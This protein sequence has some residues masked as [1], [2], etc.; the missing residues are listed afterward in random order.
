[1]KNR[2]FI[3]MAIGILVVFGLLLL[4]FA[5]WTP[6]KVRYYTDRLQSDDAD[7]RINATRELLRIGDEGRSVVFKWYTLLYDSK[8]VVQRIKIVDELCDM[9]DAGRNIMREIFI[10][11]CRYEQVR[12]PAGSFM[13][14]S[15]EGEEC[16]KPVHEVT[17]SGFW[18]D[19]Y[20]VTNEKYYVFVKCTGR[21]K[22]SPVL[23]DMFWNGYGIR[24]TDGSSGGTVR[25]QA[26][27]F[28]PVNNITWND[29]KAYADWLG[30]RLPTE[31]E[32]EYA[33]RAGSTGKWCFGDNKAELGE[34]A[35][36]AKNTDN[37][38]HPVGMKKPNKWGLYDMHGNVWEWCVDWYTN[39]YY[40][41]SPASYPKSSSSRG[42][43]RVFRGGSLNNRAWACRSAFRR[44]WGLRHNGSQIGLRLCRPASA[45]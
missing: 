20:E 40:S 10:D 17:L 43:W 26:H 25:Y 6:I 38:L 22:P 29:A 8:D 21:R 19:K 12:I 4:G 42:P 5:M 45:R 34:Y 14:G 24:Y 16:E 37:D 7:V 35:W 9:G 23:G 1:M 28:H 32:W 15:E 3:Y 11:R 39:D 27:A 13:M 30:M 44:Y 31:A 2:F 33:C 36:Y 41:N 18:M